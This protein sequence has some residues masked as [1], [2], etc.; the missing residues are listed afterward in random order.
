MFESA[1]TTLFACAATALIPP[2][3][4]GTVTWV[5][6]APR[7]GL[8]ARPQ[9]VPTKTKLESGAKEIPQAPAREHPGGSA[10]AGLRHVTPP[11]VER[12]MPAWLTVC[13]SIQTVARTRPGWLGD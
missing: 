13:E 5:H 7:S 2:G 1:F 3:E 12:Q 4:P 8:T 11:S 10:V 9:S 6:V